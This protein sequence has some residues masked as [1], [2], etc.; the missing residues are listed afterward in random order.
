MKRFFAAAILCLISATPVSANYD[1]GEAAFGRG[2]YATALREWR[3]LADQ[4]HGVSQHNLCLLY[5][6]GQGVSLDYV[7]AYLWCSLA[8]PQGV[9]NADKDLEFLAKHMTPDQI[10]AGQK[11]AREWWARHGKSK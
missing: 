6:T 4:G 10:A 3:G 2:D 8:A 11:M 7:K 9:K 5:A 1:D